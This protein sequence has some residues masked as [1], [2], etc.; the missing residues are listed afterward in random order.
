MVSVEYSALLDMC[1]VLNKHVTH[2]NM[3]RILTHIIP[4]AKQHTENRQTQVFRKVKRK[5]SH[6]TELSFINSNLACP[7]HLNCLQH[8]ATNLG[9]GFLFRSILFYYIVITFV[10]C[11][12][13]F[14]RCYICIRHDYNYSNCVP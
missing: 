4:R 1:D 7:S 2:I 13:P 10:I 8:C 9:N 3:S 11:H 5:G 12:W 6:S 14:N